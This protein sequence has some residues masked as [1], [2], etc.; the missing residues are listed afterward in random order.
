MIDQLHSIAIKVCE[1]PVMF[2]LPFSV[3]CMSMASV[4]SG[5]RPVMSVSIL[6]V[7]KDGRFYF[8]FFEALLALSVH[9]KS[10]LLLLGS[11]I[12]AFRVKNESRRISSCGRVSGNFRIQTRSSSFFIVGG[13]ISLVSLCT[14]LFSDFGWVRKRTQTTINSVI[15]QR[16]CEKTTKLLI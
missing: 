3:S 14:L 1:V 10:L 8:Y 11:Y 6:I 4:V 9:E 12:R 2:F 15:R 5:K 16:Q 13:F 7:G